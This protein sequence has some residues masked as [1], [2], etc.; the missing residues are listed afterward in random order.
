M[1]PGPRL[2]FIPS[3]YKT[4]EVFKSKEDMTNVPLMKLKQYQSRPGKQ[5]LYLEL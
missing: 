4:Q 5:N 1:G 3:K 2:D